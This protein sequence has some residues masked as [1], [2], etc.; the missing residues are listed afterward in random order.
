MK[1]S[2]FLTRTL[3]A[4]VFG[5]VMIASILLGPL[6]FGALMLLVVV[7]GMREFYGL[8][9]A[10]VSSKARISGTIIAAAF[11]L[12]VFVSNL[13]WV[14]ERLFWSLPFLLTVPFIIAMF[15]KMGNP[16]LSAGV[17]LSGIFFV[18]APLSLFGSL[19]LLDFGDTG[20]SGKAFLLI[21]LVVLWTYDSFAYIIGSRIG[22]H[23]LFKRLSPGK[24]W[25]GGIGGLI[26][27]LFATWIISNLYSGISLANWLVI[28]FMIM[29]FGTLGDLIESMFKRNAGVKDSGKLLPG[30]GGVLDRFDAVLLAAPAVYMYLVLIVL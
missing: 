15:D 24:S 17:T 1:Q 9:H 4:L 12:L 30:H 13:G 21:F 20:I 22:K 2:D 19:M 18:A 16:A 14:E 7:Q 6:Y 28:A 5:F 29:V 3:T 11:Y 8:F 27:G 23:K 10:T 26:C 25:E